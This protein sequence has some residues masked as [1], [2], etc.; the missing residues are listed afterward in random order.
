MEAMWK[1]VG[2]WL[3]TLALAA[4]DL[5]EKS[6]PR[7]WFPKSSEAALREKVANDPLAARLHDAVLAEAGRVLKARTCRYEIPD[8]K[9]LL[10]ESRLALHNVMHSA[11]AWRMS[12]AEKFRL[13]T[14]VEL[15]AACSLKD[16]NP[17]HFL[18]TAEMATAV[19]TGYDWLYPTLT[20]EQRLM[21]E[22]AIIDKALKPAKAVYQTGGWWSKPRN[23][24]SQV[25]GSGIA[26]AA[27]AVAGKD[28]G[29]SLDLFGRGLVLVENCGEFYAPDGMYPEGPG[30]WHYGTDY[31]VM[32]LAA[33][34]LLGKPVK[35]DMLLHQ[36]GNAIMHLTSPTRLPFNFA[37]G[38]AGLE[39][40]SPA[41]SWLALEFKDATQAHNVRALF[42][43]ALNEG[44]KKFV[45]GRCAPLSL[46]WLPQAPV[47][48]SPGSTAAVFHGEQAVATFRT[49]WGPDAAWFAIKG[50]TPAA[51]HGHMDVG[52][53]VYDAHGLRWLHDLGSENYNLPGH[54]GDKRWTYF[55]L[56]NRSHNTLEIDG[57]LQ[58][59]DSKPC[60]LIT[61]SLTGNPVTAAFDLSGAYARAAGK[62][63]RR[64]SF[65]TQ[66]G[67][68]RIEDEITKPVGSVCWRAF[69]DAEAVIKG[70]RVV[71]RKQGK[72][73]TLRRITGA[74]IWSIAAA[75]PPTA[76]EKQNT[77]FRALVLTI[78]KAEQ[79]SAVVEIRP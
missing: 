25:C 72:Q 74:G 23:N 27:A 18:D 26:L 35:N 32:L 28:E 30:Y 56:Q 20:P 67:V 51:S 71:L 70:D 55:R 17:S 37:D 3:G 12:G 33:S 64:A 75:T 43:R 47:A 2:I 44:G 8:G 19:A 38:H 53:F 59:R 5:A 7:L 4:S 24:W 78:P 10:K 15:E 9:R 36:G 65:D 1:L 79:L 52:S 39:T 45:G 34:Q 66:S 54:F 77:Q 73:I 63:V 76:A 11:W 58:N 40:P 49:G 29:L 42:T 31:H 22:R 21:C 50:G 46:L 60:P 13:R 16:W 41:Q 6:H 57:Q 69:T 68:V 61:S 62:V 14:I 48:G